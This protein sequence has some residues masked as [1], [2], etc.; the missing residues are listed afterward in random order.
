MPGSDEIQFGQEKR[1]N[2]KRKIGGAAVLLCLFLIAAPWIGYC[3]RGGGSDEPAVESQGPVVKTDGSI[4]VPGYESLT[5]RADRKEQEIEL[6]N[7]S[8]NDCWFQVSLT[9]ADGTLLWRSGLFAPGK[10]SGRI[11]LQGAL[12]AGS[13]PDAV[14]HYDCFGMDASLTPLNGAEIKLTLYVK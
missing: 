12:T 3:L 1:R 6:Y 7:P 8:Q 5:F 9:L 4:S 11:R 2:V 13:Y 10:T 14:L